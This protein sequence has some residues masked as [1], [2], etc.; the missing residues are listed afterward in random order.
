[1]TL[2]DMI[3]ELVFE[4]TSTSA[5]L[6]WIVLAFAPLI[7]VTAQLVAGRIIPIGFGVIY[8]A[9][10]VAYWG[11]AGGGYGSLTDVMAL[12]SHPGTATAGWIHF[13]AFD[14]FVGAWITLDAPRRGLPHLAVLPCLALTFLF[15]PVGLLLYLALT[16]WRSLR[17]S[18]TEV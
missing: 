1:M 10:I 8:A 15:G 14:L 16:Q 5:L 4:I 3:P 2:H 18:T 9:M 12:L 13:L 11:A 6:G 17:R 7:P